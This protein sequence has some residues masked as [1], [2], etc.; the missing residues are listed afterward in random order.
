IITAGNPDFEKA[1]EAYRKVS[2]KYRNALHE[3]GK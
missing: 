2:T 1:M 3:L